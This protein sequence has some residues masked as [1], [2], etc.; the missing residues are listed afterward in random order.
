MN[1]KDPL[2][3]ALSFTSFNKTKVKLSLWHGEIALN[4]ANIAFLFIYW[5]MLKW[6]DKNNS[7]GRSAA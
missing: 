2:Q 6:L 7:T 3:S 1:K 4:K 5:L